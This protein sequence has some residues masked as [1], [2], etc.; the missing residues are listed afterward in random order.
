MTTPV[1]MPAR[2]WADDEPAEATPPVVLVSSRDGHEVPRVAGAVKLAAVA[3]AAG[4]TAR[5]TYALADVPERRY[6]NGN[7]ATAPFRVAS[8]A[9]RLSR[10]AQ[11]GY[12]LW[13]SVDEGPW[14]FADALLGFVGYGLRDL[15]AALAAPVGEG[16][17]A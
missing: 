5:Q 10:G 2:R 16:R 15:T 1:T 4:W 6:Q 9:V 14:R 12:A 7:V 3:E 17:A 8:V 13:R 11:R